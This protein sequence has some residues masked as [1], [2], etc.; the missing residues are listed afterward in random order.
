[1][2]DDDLIAFEGNDQIART[3]DWSII[4]IDAN[5]ITA[6]SIPANSIASIQF[7]QPSYIQFCQ[8]SYRYGFTYDYTNTYNKQTRKKTPLLKKKVLSNPLFTLRERD[9]S[10][11]PRE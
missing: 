9:K 11:E 1:M 8:P 4:S 7:C 2:T 6:G 5:S 3:D 10:D